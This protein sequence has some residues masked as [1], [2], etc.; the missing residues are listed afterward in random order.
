M[1]K[2]K[3]YSPPLSTKVNTELSSKQ[4]NKFIELGVKQDQHEEDCDCKECLEK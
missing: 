4:V 3:G 2:I 1:F